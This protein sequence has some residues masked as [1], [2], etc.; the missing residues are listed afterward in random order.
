MTSLQK[1]DP[2]GLFIKKYLPHLKN[3]SEEY[4]YEPWK[5]SIE[6]QIKAGCIIG[7]DYPRKVIKK[8]LEEDIFFEANQ[9]NCT[10]RYGSGSKGN[11]PVI[12][13]KV[14]FKQIDEESNNS[15]NKNIFDD[16]SEDD[17]IK[18]SHIKASTCFE[19]VK[20]LEPETIESNHCIIFRE[21]KILNCPRDILIVF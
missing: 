19:T 6:D 1:L 13:P 2:Q 7:A 17:K 15:I 10:K 21:D 14:G 12:G 18:K 9:I 5:A 8:S 11:C 4:I 16:G 20:D 3:F